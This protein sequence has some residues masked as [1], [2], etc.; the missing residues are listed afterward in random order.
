MSSVRSIE[1]LNPATATPPDA[2][3]SRL[4]QE[5]IEAFELVGWACDAQKHAGEPLRLTL[6]ETE[7][8]SLSQR[9]FERADVAAAIGGDVNQPYGFSKLLPPELWRH[10]AP[11]VAM[12]C[13]EADRAALLPVPTL[14]SQ[15]DQLARLPAAQRSEAQLQVAVRATALSGGPER[16]PPELQRWL[17]DE[18]QSR[19]W[20]AGLSDPQA[21]LPEQ[22]SFPAAL[23]RHDGLAWSGWIGCPE[24]GT[25]PV[26]LLCNGVPVQAH[27][28]RTDRADVQRAL[29]SEHRL[30][31]FELE[32]PSTIWQHARGDE[33][34]ALELRVG[35][36]RIHPDPV[37]LA[38]SV[39]LDQLD[40]LQQA[41]ASLPPDASAPSRQELQ[42]QILLLIEHLAVSPCRAQLSEG[43]RQFVSQQVERFQ[44]QALWSAGEAP[45]SAA[46]AAERLQKE[47]PQTDLSTVL[48]WGLMR[49]FNALLAPGP[50]DAG[51][52]LRHLE[53]V[54]AAPHA[55]GDVRQRFLLGLVPFFCGIGAYGQ[56]RPLLDP[57]LLRQMAQSSSRWECS[58]ALPEL[59]A[60]QDLWAATKV[61]ERLA[62]PSSGWINTECVAEATRGLARVRPN[63]EAG[64]A[65]I[66]QLLA[67]LQ[68]ES[69]G[70]WGRSHDRHL[71]QTQVEL[72]LLVTEQPR[73]DAGDLIALCTRAHALNPSFWDAWAQR[74][75]DPGRWP[76]AL[77]WNH[78]VFTRVQGL[79]QGLTG[80]ADD[81]PASQG[82]APEL[83]A[84]HAK[85]NVEAG[86]LLRELAMVQAADAEPSPVPSAPDV[87]ALAVLAPSEP[88]RLW[89]HPCGEPALQAHQQVDA[90]ALIRSHSGIPHPPVVALRE[91]MLQA[92]HRESAGPARPVQL[93][94]LRKL[95][96]AEHDFLGVRLL[97]DHWWACAPTL[98]QA[99]A[100]WLTELREQW[101]QAFARSGDHPHPAQALLSSWHRLE[102]CAPDDLDA[103]R[104]ADECRRLLVARHGPRVLDSL[105]GTGPLRL[106]RRSAAQD[107]LVA[108]YS[109]RQNLGTR[110]K[111]IRETWLQDLE[112]RGVP[113]VIVVGDG[114]GQVADG[115]LGLPCSDAYEHLPQKTL[116]L[117]SWVHEHTDFEHLLKIDD[118]CHL[119]VD[120]FFDAGNHLTQHYLGR[121]LHRQEGDTD[122][123]WHCDRSRSELG[124]SAID[125][126]PEPSTYAD[127]GAG[128]CVSRHAL[129]ELAKVRASTAGARLQRSA[130]MEDK[131][132]GDLLLQAGI[133][134]SSM[135]HET[136]VRRRF[137]PGATPVNAYQNV[138]YPSASSPTVVAHLDDAEPLPQVQAAM[139][140]SALRPAR[141][142]PSYAP[143]TLGGQ[144]D[145]NQLE[146]LS[147]LSAVARLR[148][149]PVLVIAVARNERVLMPHFLQH[150][151]DLGVQQFLLVDNLSDDGTREYLLSQPDVVLYSADTQYRHSHYGVAWQQALLAGHALG[152]WVVLADIDEFL[153]YPDHRAKSL[154]EWLRSLDDEGADAAMTLMID[155][156]PACPLASASFEAQ[157]PFG[158]APHFD[159]APLLPWRLGSGCFSNGPTYLSALR[160]RLIPDSAPN[161][162]TSQKLAVFRY[163]PWVRLSEGLHYA[164][165]LQVSATPAFFAHFKYHAGFRDK[166]LQEI[167]RKQHFNGAEEYQRYLRMLGEVQQNLHSPEQSSRFGA[168]RDFRAALPE[169]DPSHHA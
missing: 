150:Y 76:L 4:V 82:L 96:T 71:I 30:L 116:A 73:G 1:A 86:M 47:A 146:L 57:M 58:L 70:Y 8:P 31:G 142:W 152:K 135:G 51:S 13:S 14:A 80:L 87:E 79:L 113:W 56:L 117:L 102:T 65:L 19:G 97:A 32:L 164:S 110:V 78:R 112:R 27:L 2:V 167:E 11:A 50:V 53:A 132:L 91:A 166:V 138:F 38:S 88:L 149:A 155:M 28:V 61:V 114:D 108:V 122:R 49:R 18:A 92:L 124:R 127:G 128:Y 59:V 22:T 48:V 75:P 106:A 115:V 154:P 100:E 17:L 140:G 156:Y 83:F 131:L 42:Y 25:P 165:N 147:P 85:G 37:H 159:R 20:E 62:E 46:S 90:A 66:Q 6:D 121:R 134:L 145:I 169:A 162:Y 15:L 120:R 139:A 24:A 163:R 105:P 129:A 160:H 68:R 33:P 89:A 5:R 123:R 137:G 99:A 144:D 133:G 3:A 84:L 157:S 10:S 54:L 101:V 153:V 43:Q 130:Y 74:Q 67:L 143:P 125:K 126:S 7:A 93:D 39:L 16:L 103:R 119:A 60:S 55:R 69:T 72:L 63:D 23:E 64:M 45:A 26:K 94:E 151:R 148:E 168:Y 104:V 95:C 111:R 41:T 158:L 141:L 77:R 35:K 9:R 12:V 161:L 29:R 118:D 98:A 136:L 34:L 109:C 40:T 81:R 21:P 36:R 107:T 44:L 52:A